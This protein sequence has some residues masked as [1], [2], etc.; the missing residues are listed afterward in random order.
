MGLAAVLVVAGAVVAAF[1]VFGGSSQDGVP[2]PAATP[3]SS[4][5]QPDD[6]PP[7]PDAEVARR[8][9]TYLER[10]AP[11]VL[12]MH[13]AAQDLAKGFT[14]EHCGQVADTLDRD[15]PP[16]QMLLAISGIADEPLRNALDA[17]RLS[18]AA[19]L[20]ACAKGTTT[21]PP[22]DDILPLPEITTI[23]QARLDALGAAR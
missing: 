2:V 20:T 6:E 16:D 1:A 5:N 15:A 12:V 13:R 4:S 18:L 9:L 11:T 19:T 14:L 10:D 17:E 22:A 7:A 8:T 21:V 3:T 23:V